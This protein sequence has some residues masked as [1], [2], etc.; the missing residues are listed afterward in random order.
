MSIKSLPQGTSAADLIGGCFIMALVDH[1]ERDMD[2]GDELSRI[3]Q[4]QQLIVKENVRPERL[5]NPFFLDTP[6]KECLVNRD[7]PASQRRDHPS[8]RRSTSCRDDRSLDS[9]PV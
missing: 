7:I 9:S 1:P 8:V 2:R 5:K 4:M 6:K 3:L